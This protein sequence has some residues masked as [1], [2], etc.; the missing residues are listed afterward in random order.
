MHARNIEIDR[1]IRDEPSRSIRTA[2][3]LVQR[4]PLVPVS[5]IRAGQHFVRTDSPSEVL[6]LMTWAGGGFADPRYAWAVVVAIN[7]DSEGYV[8]GQLLRLRTSTLVRVVHEA[9]APVYVLEI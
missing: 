2:P 5:E 1:I 4:K 9:R 3:P 8:P 6:V 7:H